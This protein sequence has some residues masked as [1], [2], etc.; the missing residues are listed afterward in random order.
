[1]SGQVRLISL[2]LMSAFLFIL[3]EFLN[4]CFCISEAVFTNLL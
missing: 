4:L 1:M 3:G 2:R